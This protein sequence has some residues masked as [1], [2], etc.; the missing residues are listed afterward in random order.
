MRFDATLYFDVD[1]PSTVARVCFTCDGDDA[2]GA[3]AGLLAQLGD[4]EHGFAVKNLIQA[5]VCRE[6]PGVVRCVLAHRP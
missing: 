3:L 2:G 1:D 4:D 5:V 6:D